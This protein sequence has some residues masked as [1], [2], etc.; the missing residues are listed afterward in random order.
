MKK[1]T[2]LWLVLLFALAP[3]AGCTRD[4]G[5]VGSADGPTEIIIS[6]VK[7]SRS[8]ASRVCRRRDMQVVPSIDA[9]PDEDAV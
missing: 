2:A 9:A 4:A 1:L 3:L 6:T 5:I 8:P 7:A